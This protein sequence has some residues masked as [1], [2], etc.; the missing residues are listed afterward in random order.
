MAKEF[1][2]CVSTKASYKASASYPHMYLPA[3]MQLFMH[4]YFILFETWDK[5]IMH[6]VIAYK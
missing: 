5:L 2:L 6:K 4:Y 3:Y 1:Q